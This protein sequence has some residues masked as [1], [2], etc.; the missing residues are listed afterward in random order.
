MTVARTDKQIGRQFRQISG[1]LRR[2]L[3]HQRKSSLPWVIVQADALTA[4]TSFRELYLSETHERKGLHYGYDA[5]VLR[6]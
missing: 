2:E 5:G 6:C 4:R 3:A 1:L